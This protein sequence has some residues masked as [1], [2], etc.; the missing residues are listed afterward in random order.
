M[1]VVEV[2]EATMLQ[3]GLFFVYS[4]TEDRNRQFAGNIDGKLKLMSNQELV[5]VTLPETTLDVGEARCFCGR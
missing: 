4:R 3:E 2:D 5:E 1:T